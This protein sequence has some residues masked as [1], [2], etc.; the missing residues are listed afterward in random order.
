MTITHFL[1]DWATLIAV[2]GLLGIE[3]APIK[4]N[5]I[6]WTLRKIGNLLNHDIREEVDKIATK[7]DKLEENQDF[8]EV[9]N[10]KQRITN[11]HALLIN[12]GLD[13]NQ[14]RRCFELESKYKFFKEKYPGRVNGHMDAMLESIHNNYLKGN[15][16]LMEEEK[17]ERKRKPRKQS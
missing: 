1:K 9:F 7:V 5:P 4:I 13:E 17:N 12:S 11:Y 10:I 6:R 8:V 15:I 14:Y 2:L 16:I 3:I